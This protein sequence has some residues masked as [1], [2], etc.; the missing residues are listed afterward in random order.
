MIEQIIEKTSS[1]DVK[2]LIVAAIAFK[3]DNDDIYKEA[4]KIIGASNCNCGPIVNPNGDN[5]ICE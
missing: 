4:M 2:K 5:G 3:A 1:E